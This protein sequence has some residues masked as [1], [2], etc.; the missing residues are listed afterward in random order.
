MKPDIES[1]L[2]HGRDWQPAVDVANWLITEKLDGVRAYWDGSQLWTRSGNLIN[3]PAEFIAALPQ[4]I[5]LDGEI[6]AGRGRL[7]EAVVAAKFGRFTARTAFHVFDSPGENGT[8]LHRMAGVRSYFDETPQLRIVA[9]EVLPSIN[10]LGGFFD[11]VAAA[12][13]EGLML[14]SP[15]ADVYQAGARTHTL[16]KFKA[17][18]AELLRNYLAL[19][20]A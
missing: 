14:R 10:E 19:V 1:L 13:G 20:A 9:H 15:T 4:R 17:P 11:A 8:W 3:A 6:W 7:S 5:A 16:L 2:M 18:Q 12:G